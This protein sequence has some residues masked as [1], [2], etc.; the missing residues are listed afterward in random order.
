[1]SQPD[2]FTRDGL[3]SLRHQ[4]VISAAATSAARGVDTDIA[5]DAGGGAGPLLVSAGGGG[6][7]VC[8]A[9]GGGGGGASSPAVV[10]TDATASVVVEPAMDT[11]LDANAVETAEASAAVPSSAGVTANS[12]TTEPSVI[13]V[14]KI[15]P[16]VT[17]I[18]AATSALK[19]VSNVVRATESSG[20]LAKSV[21]SVSVAVTVPGMVVTV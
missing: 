3:E 13:D 5:P 6:G 11:P 1:M 4:A 16:A 19:L 20:M 14:M 8:S 12:T 2:R 18:A 9:G 10:A 21:A 7:G 17:P 15:C